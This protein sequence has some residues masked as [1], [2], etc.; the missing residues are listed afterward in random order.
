MRSFL[1][2]NVLLDLLV[3]NDVGPV[4]Q[5]SLPTKPASAGGQL[6]VLLEDISL[7]GRSPRTSPTTLGTHSVLTNRLLETSIRT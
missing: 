1:Q 6:L 5:T 4:I 7:T 3:G 2:A